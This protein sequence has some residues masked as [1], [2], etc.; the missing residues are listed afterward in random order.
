MRAFPE[1][2]YRGQ[3]QRL[4]RLARAALRAYDLEVS[5]IAAIGNYENATFRVAG[6]L[7]DRAGTATFLLRVHRPGYHS[8]AEIE[9]EMLWLAALRASPELSVPVA[10]AARSGEHVV[11][12][13]ADGVPEPRYCSLLR[14]VPGRNLDRSLGP[15]HLTAIG[16]SMAALHRCSRGLDT[17]PGFTRPRWDLEALIG[18][19]GPWAVPATGSVAGSA[20]DRVLELAR[21]RARAELA[22]VSRDPRASGLIHADLHHGN[23]VFSAGRAHI[24]DFDDCGFGFFAY[25]IAVALA[26]LRRRPDYESLRQALLGGYESVSAIPDVAALPALLMARDLIMVKWVS[27]RLENPRLRGAAPRIVERAVAGAKRYVDGDCR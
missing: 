20:D 3:L 1:L 17:P 4:G 9:S 2:S 18:S 10:V 15:A 7:G 5:K 14:W 16:R 26:H 27:G 12:D 21:A 13:G 19:G 25:D 8:R 24:I 6:R 11:Q 23:Y 22:A